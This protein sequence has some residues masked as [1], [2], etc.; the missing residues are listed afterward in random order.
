VLT[1]RL[2]TD[3]AEQGVD[4]GLEVL[5]LRLQFVHSLLHVNALLAL[6]HRASHLEELPPPIPQSQNSLL[7]D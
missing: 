1:V 2:L 6:V 7:K 4:E 3:Y 5:H